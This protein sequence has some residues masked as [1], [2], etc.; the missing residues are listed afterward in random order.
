MEEREDELDKQAG[1][2]VPTHSGGVCIHTDR[3]FGH[4]M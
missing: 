1:V 2:R 4:E 3:E